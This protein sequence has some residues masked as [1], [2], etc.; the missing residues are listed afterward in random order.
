MYV[1][2]IYVQGCSAYDTLCSDRKSYVNV[3]KNETCI[4]INKPI[5]S[6]L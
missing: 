5:S 2:S 4:M 6:M 1:Y 3:S